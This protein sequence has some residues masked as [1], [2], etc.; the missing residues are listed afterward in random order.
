MENGAKDMPALPYKSSNM[1]KHSCCSLVWYA[2]RYTSWI[3]LDFNGGSYIVPDDI[4]LDN[5]VQYISV[6]GM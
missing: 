5:D 1:A 6:Q 3:D 2:Y 4:A